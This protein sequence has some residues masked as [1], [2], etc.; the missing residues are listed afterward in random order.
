MTAR[1][2]VLSEKGKT[3]SDIHKEY[4]SDIAECRDVSKQ[5]LRTSPVTIDIPEGSDNRYPRGCIFAEN[6]VEWN[7]HSTGNAEKTTQSICKADNEYSEFI[8]YIA[9]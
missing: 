4:L 9:N 5:L 3:C 6:Q 7:S 2:F 1:S 8:F